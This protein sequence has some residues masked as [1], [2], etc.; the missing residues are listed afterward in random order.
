[1]KL[2]FAALTLFGLSIAVVGGFGL[3]GTSAEAGR[4]PGTQSFTRNCQWICHPYIRKARAQTCQ[5]KAGRRKMVYWERM[6]VAC[7]PNEGDD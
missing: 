3:T 4:V 1:M 5:N 6:P 7:D 2:F